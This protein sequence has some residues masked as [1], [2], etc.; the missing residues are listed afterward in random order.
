M[1]SGTFYP[2]VGTDD[3]RGNYG[4]SSFDN[5]DAFLYCGIG[6]DVG[7]RFVNVAI[8]QGVTITSAFIRF[9]AHFAKTTTNNGTADIWAVDADNPS[10]PT[11]SAQFNALVPTSASV[12]WEPPT[13]TEGQ[14]YDTD[15]ITSVIQEIID[16]EG[17]SSGNAIILV[18]QDTLGNVIAPSTWM[19]A[20]ENGSGEAE[21]HVTWEAAEE[22]PITRDAIL[23]WHLTTNVNRETIIK[24]N[25]TN[26]VL[27][28]H[29]F[30]WGLLWDG[31]DTILRWS[32]N[33]KIAKDT[34]LKWNLIELLPVSRDTILRWALSV[35]T[36]TILKWGLL[37]Y[38]PVN[39]DTI[40]KWTLRHYIVDTTT[41]IIPIRVERD[42]I[43]R[44][45]LMSPYTNDVIILYDIGVAGRQRINK[46]SIILFDIQETTPAVGPVTINRDTVLPFDLMNM[47]TATNIIRY[48]ILNYNPVSK[49]TIFRYTL[50]GK[51]VIYKI[52]LT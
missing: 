9:R 37:Q 49:D 36:D 14:I 5:N 3:W 51:P 19:S 7:F 28:D 10:A 41:L 18:A 39:I 52:T 40:L 45:A 4:G 16:R 50:F 15:D 46:D 47:V 34:I 30:K 26:N 38:T 6:W 35:S 29:I 24:Y 32:L 1:A 31:A 12:A 22:P 25:L 21:L 23:S 33:E 8:P 27:Q 20:V 17:F 44:N 2:V 13:T 43:L 42:L 11:N 48:N